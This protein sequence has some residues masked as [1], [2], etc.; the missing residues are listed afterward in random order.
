MKPYDKL[1]LEAAPPQ[2][3]FVVCERLELVAG[4]V[5][6][7]A[8]AKDSEKPRDRYDWRVGPIDYETFARGKDPEVF[9]ETQP[10]K[11]SFASRGEDD[12]AHLWAAKQAARMEALEPLLSLVDLGKA[13][14]ERCFE[15]FK[16]DHDWGVF[17]LLPNE[18][19]RRPEIATEMLSERLT[20][21]K[22]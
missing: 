18:I 14:M 10:K 15:V 22:A 13:F 1:L 11:F 3:I 8:V 6:Y 19:E 4:H 9:W 16:W 17:T 7:Y 5:C 21:E 12:A 20:H 2:V